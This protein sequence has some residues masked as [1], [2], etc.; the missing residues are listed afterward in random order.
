MLRVDEHR[1]GDG[2]TLSVVWEW[3]VAHVWWTNVAFVTLI[4]VLLPDDVDPSDPL[5]WGI[6]GL[7]IVLLWAPAGARMRREFLQHYNRA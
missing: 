1:D 5:A 7:A 6:F 3:L 2:G 4:V